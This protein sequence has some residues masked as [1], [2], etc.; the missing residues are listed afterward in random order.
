MRRRSYPNTYSDCYPNTY[1]HRNST[2]SNPYP[3]ANTHSNPYPNP[4][5]YPNTHTH[6][7]T[8]TPGVVS[9]SSYPHR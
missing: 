8:F 1:T 5:P 9:P 2:H 3:N 7:Y 4:N 6:S